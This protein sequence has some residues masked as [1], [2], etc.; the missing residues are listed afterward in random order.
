M[1][2]ERRFGI[3][4][5]FS[6]IPSPL[7]GARG[8]NFSFFPGHFGL[9]HPR[10]LLPKRE[11][12]RRRFPKREGLDKLEGL[13]NYSGL[14]TRFE[15]PLAG[16]NKL[17]NTFTWNPG[18]PGLARTLHPFGGTRQWFRT[19]KGL[20]EAFILGPTGRHKKAQQGP[21]L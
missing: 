1:A 10:P 7:Q 3:L 18:F 4:A 17:S 11:G 14:A 15:N 5:P 9:Q 6:V 16:H 21:A 12:G 19:Q 8:P 13:R 20:S 2:E